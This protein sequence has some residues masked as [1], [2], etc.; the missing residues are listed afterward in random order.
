MPRKLSWQIS[1]KNGYQARK[2]IQGPDKV[3]GNLFSSQTTTRFATRSTPQWR[4]KSIRSALQEDKA[5]GAYKLA[6]IL[7]SPVVEPHNRGLK[8]IRLKLTM[9]VLNGFV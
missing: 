4:W 5:I 3:Q 2:V 6:E 9:L 7:T 1:S 8:E